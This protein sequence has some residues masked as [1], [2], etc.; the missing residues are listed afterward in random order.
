MLDLMSPL[1]EASEQTVRA[2][3]AGLAARKRV[4]RGSTIRPGPT[5]PLWNEVVS[6]TRPYLARRGEKAKLA[7][8]LGVPR[9]RIHDYFV[10]ATA[11]ADAERLLLLLH[12]LA[13]RR[14]GK[15]PA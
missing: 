3:S 8:I 10:G 13:L 9:Q 7:R 2:A 1:V 6:A 12:W 5:T 15:D 14:A 4:R 11:C